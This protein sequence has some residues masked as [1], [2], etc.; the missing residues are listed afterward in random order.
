MQISREVQNVELKQDRCFIL[1]RGVL[2]A[3]GTAAPVLFSS[4]H[5][6]TAPLQRN[7]YYTSSNLL[8]C[9]QVGATFCYIPIIFKHC[10]KG[11]FHNYNFVPTTVNLWQPEL[12]M[13]S[14]ACVNRKGAH[15][16]FYLPALSSISSAKCVLL[17]ILSFTTG[18]T[19]CLSK[20]L[21]HRKA[22]FCIQ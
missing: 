9:L 11:Q 15:S 7:T 14:P 12:T 17:L 1:R 13:Q 18:A 19:L 2:S 22:V 3:P 6:I 21:W 16:Q 10:Y 5:I 8:S 4:S 20:K